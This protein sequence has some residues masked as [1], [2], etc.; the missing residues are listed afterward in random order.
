MTSSSSATKCGSMSCSTAGASRRSRRF[1][2]WPSGRSRSARRARFSRSPAGRS[3]GWS[4]R[5]ISRVVARAHQF[6]TF[7]TAPNLQSAVA[8]GLDEVDGWIAADARSVR[9][10]PQPD[11]RR[12]CAPPAMP[13]STPPRP[14]SCAST[15]RH[16]ASARRR[17][18]RDGGG[19]EGRR[20]RCSAVGVRRAGPAAS[21]C[22]AVLRQEG[23]DDRRRRRGNGEGEG[24]ARM[25]PPR[26]PR[27]PRS[28]RVRRPQASWS[29][30]RRSTAARSGRYR[31]RSG[32]GLRARGR[33]LLGLAN[34]PGAAAR[35]AGPPARRGI[36]RRRSR[37]SAR[38]VTL[39][40]GKILSGEPRRSAGDDRHLRFRGR[41][42]APA[43]RPHHRQRAARPPDDGAMASARAGAGDHRVQFPG[44]GLGVERGAGAGLRRSGGLEAVREDAA[45]RRSW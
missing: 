23:R 36:A 11:D 4:P 18:F 24:N 8:F 42:L 22:A 5:P 37:R 26:K 25:S 34:G 39:E 17:N 21:P 7:S 30:I 27:S 43:L 38:L 28:F 15:L 1:P 16:P 9:T 13:C 44:R 2:A 41:P 33:G 29:P 6:L 32:G 14:T 31:W 45:L 20:G 35:R 3:A 10:R 12:T 40:A 19:R